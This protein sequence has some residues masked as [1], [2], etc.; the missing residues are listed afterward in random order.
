MYLCYRVFDNSWWLNM[1][2]IG[3]TVLFKVYNFVVRVVPR[4]INSLY[5]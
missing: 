2:I 3:T 4:H 1:T 5:L